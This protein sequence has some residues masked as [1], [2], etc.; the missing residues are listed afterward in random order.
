MIANRRDLYTG[1]ANKDVPANLLRNPAKVSLTSLRKFV[2]V[3]YVDKMSLQ[4][5][6]SRGSQIRE[7]VRREIMHYLSSVR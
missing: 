4:S 1:F 5:L 6:A 2:H 7:E 3:R